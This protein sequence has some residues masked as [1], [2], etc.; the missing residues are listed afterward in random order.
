MIDNFSFLIGDIIQAYLKQK[1]C[2]PE[3]IH[4]R[5]KSKLIFEPSNINN[6]EPPEVSF[7]KSRG[8]PDAISEYNDFVQIKQQATKKIKK[9]VFIAIHSTPDY[10]LTRGQESSEILKHKF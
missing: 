5:L 2:L 7:G 6:Q 10:L 8:S 9:R 4:A 1:R 3:I